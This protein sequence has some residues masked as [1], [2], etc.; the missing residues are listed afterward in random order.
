MVGALFGLWFYMSAD[1]GSSSDGG[2]ASLSP[3][4][5]LLEASDKCPV[6][7]KTKKNGSIRPGLDVDSTDRVAIGVVCGFIKWSEKVADEFLLQV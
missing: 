3:F 4:L 7:E 6:S 1:Y 2:P 5:V